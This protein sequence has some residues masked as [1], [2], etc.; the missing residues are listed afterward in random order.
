MFSS[1]RGRLEVAISSQGKMNAKT[2]RGRAA[3]IRA[4]TTC[5]HY[6]KRECRSVKVPV[7]IQYHVLPVCIGTIPCYA[8]IPLHLLL[9]P[10]TVSSLRFNSTVSLGFTA[11]HAKP[12][13]C[14]R[15]TITKITICTFQD[16]KNIFSHPYPRKR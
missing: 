8:Q 10:N 1:G 15:D 9:R 11:L 5:L 14:Q 2:K 13:Q 4:R 7:F 12:I 3:M 16:N 6:C